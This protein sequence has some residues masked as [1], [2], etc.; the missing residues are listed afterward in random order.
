MTLCR[1]ALLG[2]FFDCKHSLFIRL[3]EAKRHVLKVARSALF[4][5]DVPCLALGYFLPQDCLAGC[6]VLETPHN[7]T[8]RDETFWQALVY[9]KRHMMNVAMPSRRDFFWVSFLLG[10]H[11][12]LGSSEKCHIQSLVLPK[13]GPSG[14]D[15]YGGDPLHFL[16]T[17]LEMAWTVTV[18]DEYAT[19]QEAVA[20]VPVRS[21]DSLSAL[22]LQYLCSS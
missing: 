15:K 7:E 16:E 2:V 21:R 5:T 17:I 1:L 12:R 6:C 13:K 4:S 8:L 10:L 20:A 14:A 11:N 19:V 22:W 9:T 18:P 3:L